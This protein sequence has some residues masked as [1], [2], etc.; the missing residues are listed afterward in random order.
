MGIWMVLSF[1]A[2][3]YIMSSWFSTGIDLEDQKDAIDFCNRL[4]SAPE[5]NDSTKDY[6][7]FDDLPHSYK[8]NAPKAIKNISFSLKGK[9]KNH[10]CCFT[11]TEE[12]NQD[13]GYR[14][15]LHERENEVPRLNTKVQTIGGYADCTGPGRHWHSFNGTKEC[16]E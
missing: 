3:F 13:W 15:C 10:I 4:F 12:G 5:I 7:S 16:V 1:A 6:L 8:E 14:D 11:S 9:S 2:F